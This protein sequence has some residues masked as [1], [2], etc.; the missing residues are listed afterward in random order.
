MVGACVAPIAEIDRLLPHAGN[1]R[2]LDA[3]VLHEPGRLVAELTVRRG[4]AF[5][6]ADGSL[7]PWVGMEIMAQAVSAYA[8]VS[9]NRAGEAPRIGLLLGVRDYRCDVGRFPEGAK[10]AA[11]VQESTRDE[12]GMA[13]FDCWL[14]NESAVVAQGMLTAFEPDDVSDFLAQQ[15]P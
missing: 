4:L 1:A 12:R 14:Y 7:L 11:H 5:S 8:T 2:L 13:V 3:V 9:S 15:A 6:E 10:L